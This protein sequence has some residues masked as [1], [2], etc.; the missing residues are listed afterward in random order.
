MTQQMSL[1]ELV[2]R[3]RAAAQKRGKKNP[4]RAL[5]FNVALALEEMGRRLEEAWKDVRQEVVSKPALYLP[6]KGLHSV[7]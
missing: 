2:R 7:N 4:D 6:G 5:L 1:D 3:V